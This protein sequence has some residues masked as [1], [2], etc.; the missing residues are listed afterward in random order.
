MKF[1]VFRVVNKMD[2]NKCMIE[3]VKNINDVDY[4]FI[5]ELVKDEDIVYFLCTVKTNQDTITE[6]KLNDIKYYIKRWI[7]NK[8]KLD[9]IYSKD[10]KIELLFN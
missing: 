1:Y 6:N 7:G 10:G 9:Q 2:D 8:L 5:Y 4:K 3:V